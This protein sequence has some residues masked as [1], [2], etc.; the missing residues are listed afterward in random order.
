MRSLLPIL[1]VGVA[2]TI[3]APIIPVQGLSDSAFAQTKK[4]QNFV[5]NCRDRDRNCF[6]HRYWRKHKSYRYGY[7]KSYRQPRPVKRRAEPRPKSEGIVSPVI[8]SSEVKASRTFAGPNQF[9]PQDYAAYGVVIFRAKASVRFKEDW[10]R[11]LAIC[12]AYKNSLLQSAELQ[13]A[14]SKQMVTVWPISHDALADRLNHSKLASVCDHAV[15]NYGLSDAQ[16]NLRA[17]Q[18]AAFTPSGRGPFLVAWAPPSTRGHTDAVVLTADLS[19]I[20]SYDAALIVMQDWVK[21]IEQNPELWKS[22]NG[23]SLAAIQ[24]ISRNWLDKHGGR[25]LAIFG[26]K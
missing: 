20:E 26:E 9:P 3:G 12:E 25:I 8:V 21:D 14:T 22:E 5:F 24:E 16:A 11:H 23:W 2:I 6:R 7:R 1:S 10:N 17:A 15:E 13:T 18:A 4:R 19:S